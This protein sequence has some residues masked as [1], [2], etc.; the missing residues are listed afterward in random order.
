MKNK[1]ELY[2]L[3]IER[4][5]DESHD[6]FS[7][8]SSV[9]YSPIPLRWYN[10]IFPPYAFLKLIRIG[11]ALIWYRDLS[12][13][14]EDKP[15]MYLVRII[16]KKERIAIPVLNEVV[17]VSDRDSLV[18]SFA[19]TEVINLS[20]STFLIKASKEESFMDY[21]E[22]ES[23]GLHHSG[24]LLFKKF[25]KGYRPNLQKIFNEITTKLKDTF[26][27][28]VDSVVQNLLTN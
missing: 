2:K 10:W 3:S 20:S 13:T 5:E 24:L 4:R 9:T 1:I 23:E 12:F 25:K 14:S 26:T 8:Y 16:P 6:G 18:P 22:E 17:F 15:P 19:G 27:G 7:N 28:D 21:F 11:Y